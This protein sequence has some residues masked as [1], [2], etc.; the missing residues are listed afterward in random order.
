MFPLNKLLLAILTG[1][2]IALFLIA[3]AVADVVFQL[4]IGIL[5]DAA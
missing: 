5:G 1:A 4:G 3:L 2:F